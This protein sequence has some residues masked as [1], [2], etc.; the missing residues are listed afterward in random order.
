MVKKV[1]H[2]CKWNYMCMYI[3]FYIKYSYM[4]IC[5]YVYVYNRKSVNRPNYTYGLWKAMRKCPTH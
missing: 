5:V 2:I 3:Y 4:Y 1:V